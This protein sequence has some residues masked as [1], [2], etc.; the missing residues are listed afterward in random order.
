MQRSSSEVRKTTRLDFVKKNEEE[1]KKEKGSGSK[2][3]KR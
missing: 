3:T 1:K 2:D